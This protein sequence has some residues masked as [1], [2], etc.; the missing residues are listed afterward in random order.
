M[1]AAAPPLATR[2]SREHSRSLRA[3]AFRGDDHYRSAAGAKVSH[4]D[5]S[6]SAAL[7]SIR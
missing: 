5:P 1:P 6:I 3:G 2:W 7:R 4:P